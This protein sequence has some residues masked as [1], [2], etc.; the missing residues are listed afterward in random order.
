M[1][2][3]KKKKKKSLSLSIVYHMLQCLEIKVT[4]VMI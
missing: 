2:Q 3:S 4:I 1:I